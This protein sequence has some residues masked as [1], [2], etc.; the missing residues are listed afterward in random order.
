MSQS[1]QKKD[2]INQIIADL[3]FAYINKD[4]DNPHAFE[5]ET[6]EKAVAYLE[7]EYNGETYNKE[8]FQRCKELVN[9][10]SNK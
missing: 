8:F 10:K 5:V 7:V 4:E 9:R 6:V 3:L 2:D 1:Q